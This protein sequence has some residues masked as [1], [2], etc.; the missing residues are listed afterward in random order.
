MTRTV[1]DGAIMLGAIAGVDARDDATRASDGHAHA[2]Y[3]PFL[4]PVGLRGARIGVARQYFDFA[5]LSRE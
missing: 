1:T 3:A 2:D 5:K 4:E